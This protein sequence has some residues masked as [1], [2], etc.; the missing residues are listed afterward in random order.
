MEQLLNEKN[1]LK[2]LYKEK[3]IVDYILNY[4][5]G[6][7]VLERCNIG[8]IPKQKSE[9]LIQ[10]KKKS[11]QELK[12]KIMTDYQRKSE[13]F[14]Q[15]SLNDEANEEAKTCSV[16]KNPIAVDE[17]NEEYSKLKEENN[18]DDQLIGYPAMISP[19]VAARGVQAIIDGKEWM[20]LSGDVGILDLHICNHP[21]HLS[22]KPESRVFMCPVCKMLR[23]LVLPSIPKLLRSLVDWSESFRL[24]GIKK[25]ITMK[26]SISF[27]SLQ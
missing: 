13:R 1:F 23:M 14:I 11:S 12:Q 9:E 18:K 24:N 26:K 22:C 10:L 3:T 25:Y 8:Y 6:E 16:C 19:S 17:T 5:E 15:H 4:D 2:A 27:F 7:F 21:F 20:C